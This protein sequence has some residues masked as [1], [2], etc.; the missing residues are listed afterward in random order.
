[1]EST[2]DGFEIADEDLILRG[3]GDYVGFKQSGFVKYKI[4]DMVKDGPIIRTARILAKSIIESDPILE[5]HENV[6]ARV[7]DDYKNN[8]HLVKLN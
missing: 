7:I 8:L 5:N 4:A 2:N 1:M 6:K 3:P